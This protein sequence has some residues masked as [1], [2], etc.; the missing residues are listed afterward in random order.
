MYNPDTGKPDIELGEEVELD[1]V[2]W[3]KAIAKLSQVSHPK[4]YGKMVKQYAELMRQEKYKKRPNM[5]ADQVA[6]EYRGVSV[7]EFIKYINTLVAKKVLPQELK[8]EYEG[9]D[10]MFTF[11]EFVDE[12]QEKKQSGFPVTS[13]GRGFQP[14]KWA[15]RPDTEAE[16]RGEKSIDRHADEAGIPRRLLK[17]RLDKESNL[18]HRDKAGKVKVGDTHLQDKAYG[19]GQIRKPALSAVNKAYDTKTTMADIKKDKHKNIQ[20]SARYL[21][22]LHKNTGNAREDEIDTHTAY[23]AGPKI[24]GHEGTTTRKAETA[25]FEKSFGKGPTKPKTPAVP[26]GTAVLSP[27]QGQQGARPPIPGRKPKKEEVDVNEDQVSDTGVR[28]KKLKNGTATTSAGGTTYRS[29]TG[30]Q[31]KHVSPRIGGVRTTTRPSAAAGPG[32]RGVTKTRDYRG[33]TGK[34]VKLNVATG[35]GGKG[36][37]ITAQSKDV[38]VSATPKQATVKVCPSSVTRKIAR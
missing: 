20:T 8:A 12:I 15:T 23:R 29:A 3:D 22:M 11:K 7:R 28:T 9:E 38:K 4:E 1:E 10:N 17:H 33:T 25:K 31:T 16:K 6:R 2:W 32:P 19:I 34:G 5:A 24:G 30:Q 14:P 36:K 35:P 18:K 13:G 37:N 26:S 27:K 21:K